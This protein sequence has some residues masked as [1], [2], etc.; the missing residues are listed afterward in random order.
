[1]TPNRWWLEGARLGFCENRNVEPL[2]E[3][4]VFFNMKVS[5]KQNRKLLA[6]V[7]LHLSERIYSKR[8]SLMTVIEIWYLQLLVT[9]EI[10]MMFSYS[11]I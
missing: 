11:I 10:K 5:V 6:S 9:F 7:Y 3:S 8:F 2:L 1:M 4:P